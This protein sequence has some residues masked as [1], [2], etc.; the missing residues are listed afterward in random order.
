MIDAGASALVVKPQAVK[1]SANFFGSKYDLRSYSPSR[2]DSFYINYINQIIKIVKHPIIFHDQ[3]FGNG[4]GLSSV[5][6]NKI[7][8]NKYICGFKLHTQD[9]NHLKNQY[10][11]LKNKICFDGFGKTTQFW[12]LQW[13]AKAMHS[14]WSWFEPEADLIFFK[15]IKQLKFKEA[16]KIINR[17]TPIIN[18]IRK[19]GFPGYKELMRLRGLPHTRSR[20]PGETLDKKNQIIINEAFKKIK[21]MKII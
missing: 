5:A 17:E 19:S 21:K 4:I 3:P 14:C 16:I 18:A 1:E 7:S 9:L 12:T 11:N 15:L 10:S 2:H 20:I 13:G 8:R 6:I